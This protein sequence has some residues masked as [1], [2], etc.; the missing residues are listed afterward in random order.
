MSRSCCWGLP[1]LELGWG[2]TCSLV[3]DFSRLGLLPLGNCSSKDYLYFLKHRFGHAHF[4]GI[5]DP[6][7]SNVVLCYYPYLPVVRPSVVRL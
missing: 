3:N 4:S 1:L 5:L 7:L 2:L 6:G